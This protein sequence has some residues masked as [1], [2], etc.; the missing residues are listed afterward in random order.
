[1]KKIGK[2]LSFLTKIFLVVGLLFSNLSG[3]SCVFAYEG[4]DSLVITL[5]DEN[6][7]VIKYTDTTL[8]I[9][10]VKMVIT[11]DYTYM[12]E[13]SETR[14]NKELDNVSVST[15]NSEEGYEYASHVEL[16]V[17]Q[18]VKTPLPFCWRGFPSWNTEAM[19]PQALRFGTAPTTRW[20]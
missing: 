7:L 5:N 13:T 4:T 8:D 18:D 14:L 19:T 2:K 1:M 10:N 9:D 17:F 15:L 11:E 12:D 16:L 20:L 3:L 6:K